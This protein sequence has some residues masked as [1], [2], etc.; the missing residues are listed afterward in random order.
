MKKLIGLI[1]ENKNISASIFFIVF[2]S[3]I[4]K[5]WNTIFTILSTTVYLSIVINLVNWLYKVFKAEDFSFFKQLLVWLKIMPIFVSLF[6]LIIFYAFSFHIGNPISNTKSIKDTIVN[7]SSN[8][9]IEDSTTNDI[10]Y[11]LEELKKERENLNN[12][13][14]QKNKK[15][16][17]NESKI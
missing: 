6:L 15:R 17:K 12:E 16:I 14:R 10:N 9:I 1:V 7:S 4:F 5:D 11:Q 13:M 2:T 3:L 8:D